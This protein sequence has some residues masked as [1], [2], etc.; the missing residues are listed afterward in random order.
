MEEETYWKEKEFVVELVNQLPAAI[1]WKNAESVFMGCNKTFAKLAGL[2][3]PQDIIGK[4]DYDL[5]WGKNQARLYRNDDL[6][7]INS[8]QAKQQIEENQTLADGKE[9]VLLTSKMPLFSRSGQVMGILGIF[10]DITDRKKMEISLAQSKDLAESAN[11]AK[12]EFLRNMEH[13]LRTP[14]SG[15]YS[16]VRLLA[17]EETQPEKKEMLELTCQ[18]AKEFLDLLNDIIDFSRFQTENSGILAKKFDLRSLLEKA[19]TMQSAAAVAKGLELTLCY[20]DDLPNIFISDPY[21]LRRIILNLLSNAIR[22]TAKG[23]V[24]VRTKLAKVID[25]K[26]MILQLIVTDTGIGIPPEK[27]TLIYEKFYRVYPANQN[28]YLGAGLGLPLVKQL[29]T[30]LEGEIEMQSSP[31]TGTVF[32]CTIPFKRPLVDE[33]LDNTD[34]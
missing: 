9:I 4:T 30:D 7:V 27:Q 23:H 14:F 28:K 26:N 21:R 12:S 11:R 6:S 24:S 32:V 3:S 15:V 25:A 20:P 10:H 16:L 34:N 33:I 5:P 8:K 31:E 22:F 19:I 17:D 2:P 18:S 1:F 13:Q 29:M